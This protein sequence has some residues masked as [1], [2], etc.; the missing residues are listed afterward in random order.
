[1]ADQVLS[2]DEKDALLEGVSNGEVEI[3]AADGP[4]YVE[5]VDFEIS[6]RARIVTNSFPR[7]LQ[8]NRKLASII[9]KTASK[10]LNAKVEVAPGALATSTYGEFCEQ[11]LETAIVYEFSA[12]PL[13]GS[14]VIYVQAGVVSHIVEAFYGGSKENPP[15]HET[16]GFTPGELNVTSLLCTDIIKGVAEIWQSLM[17]IE[18]EKVAVHQ[19]TDVNQV[20]ESGATVICTEF[21]IHFGD[22]QLYFHIVW[23]TSMLAPLL[24]VFEGQKRERDP[25]EDARWGQVLRARIPETFTDIYT[26]IGNASLNLRDVAELK[27][28]DIIDFENPRKGTVFAQNVPVLE[29]R[30]GVHDGHY[31]IET[32][33]WLGSGC[34]VETVTA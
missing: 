20:V 8:L 10:L 11:T 12:S 33:R 22:D 13:D 23:P 29:G 14:A 18:P 1:M 2:N 25:A 34:D 19:S 24:P 32:T 3:E 28:G 26:C 17:L 5:V 7:L 30:F 31:A 9:G 4:Q 21:D 6:P 16:E 27:P 15:R